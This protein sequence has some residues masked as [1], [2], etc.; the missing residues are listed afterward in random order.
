MIRIKLDRIM[1]KKGI[2]LAELAGLIG[3]TPA[4]LSR[5][6]CGKCKG[7]RFETLGN[8]CRALQC[9]VSD[10]IEFVKD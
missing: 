2:G 8:I 6:K 10:I 1:A 3:I 4:N 9:D 7:V 5:F